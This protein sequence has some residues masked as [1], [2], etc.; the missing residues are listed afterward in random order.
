MVYNWICPWSSNQAWIWLPE[1]DIIL[2]M[3]NTWCSL[4]G[5]SIIIFLLFSGFLITR[6]KVP[7]W[8]I[9][10]Y[11]ISPLQW[12]VT[13]LVC[14]E[15]LSGEYNQVSTSQP[16][17]ELLS[18]LLDVTILLRSST[19]IIDQEIIYF[20][21]NQL[22]NM[23]GMLVKITRILLHPNNYIIKNKSCWCSTSVSSISSDTS[24]SWS[25][26]WQ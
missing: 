7:H 6:N 19:T 4:A 25:H 17:G 21:P 5:V 22:M 11:Y 23:L 20:Y 15:F 2:I 18:G 24:K 3:W 10:A 8:W 26:R 12:G 13:A 14:N 9:W 1:F 16:S